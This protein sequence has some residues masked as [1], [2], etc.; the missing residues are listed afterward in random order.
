MVI[1]GSEFKK[2]EVGAQG[3]GAELSA[4]GAKHR[5]PNA[6]GE[7]YRTRLCFVVH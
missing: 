2:D 3:S 6:L 4:R 1:D 7:R 5:V